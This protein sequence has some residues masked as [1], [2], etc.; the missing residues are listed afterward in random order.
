MTKI[1][2]FYDY[3][4]KKNPDHIFIILHGYGANGEN[5]ISLAQSFINIFPNA[6]FVAPNAPQDHEMGAYNGFQW[7]SLA[8]RNHDIIA[9]EIK[10]ANNILNEFIETNLNKFKLNKKNIII[11]GFSQG[12]MM[13]MYNALSA[14]QEYK[15]VLA[16]SG[17]LILPEQIGE[18][19]NSKPKICLIH[20][21]NDDIVSCKNIDIAY[22]KLKKINISVEKNLLDNLYHEHVIDLRDLKTKWEYSYGCVQIDQI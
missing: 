18:I 22:D 5:L 1:T 16:F 6:Y 13:A 7:F 3:G 17:E 20:G 2:K 10:K 19:T 8:N 15:T 12:A 9:P 21:K 11:A 4:N 14:K